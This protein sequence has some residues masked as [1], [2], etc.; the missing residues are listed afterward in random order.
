MYVKQQQ[1]Q[2][3]SLGVF[4]AEAYNCPQLQLYVAL[5]HF[6]LQHYDWPYS[7]VG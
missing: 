4:S 1:Q 3:H 6:T 2:H 5:N 7:S